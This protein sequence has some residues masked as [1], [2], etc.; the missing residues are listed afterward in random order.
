[1]RDTVYMGEQVRGNVGIAQIV[2]NLSPKIRLQGRR[3]L[4][5]YPCCAGLLPATVLHR[6]E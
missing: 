4:L 5:P 6:L 2:Q 3:K 1:M